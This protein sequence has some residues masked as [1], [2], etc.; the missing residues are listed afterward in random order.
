MD[1]IAIRSFRDTKSRIPLA[2][3]Q[4]KHHIHK[5]AQFNIGGDVQDL[6]KIP[7]DREREFLAFLLF[8]HAV[9]LA[10]PENIARVEWELEQDRKREAHFAALDA[11]AALVATGERFQALLAQ[12]ARQQA[13]PP[14]RSR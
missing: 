5:G 2:N 3:Q 13:A 12:L 9:A 14:A 10:T 8:S 7:D 4:H 6:A 11:Q 1:L